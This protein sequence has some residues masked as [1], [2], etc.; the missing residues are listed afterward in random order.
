MVIELE[1]QHVVEKITAAEKN[2]FQLDKSTEIT[3][4]VQ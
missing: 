3:G 2:A 4:E 1:T